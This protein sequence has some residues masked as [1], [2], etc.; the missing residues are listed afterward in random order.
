MACILWKS[1]DRSVNH[2]KLWDEI[3]WSPLKLRHHVIMLNL[4]FPNAGNSLFFLP[5]HQL[6]SR[7]SVS[8][9]VV[10]NC[11]PARH[12][13]FRQPAIAG[14]RIKKSKKGWRKGGEVGRGLS[15][16][17]KIIHIYGRI[18]YHLWFSKVPN[19]N[20]RP[21]QGRIPQIPVKTNY[22]SLFGRSD[23][24]IP[25]FP[26]NFYLNDILTQTRS[27]KNDCSRWKKN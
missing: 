22:C 19:F 15:K 14:W 23:P 6:F 13:R 3:H 26:S 4:E 21:K 11:S 17:Q 5:S 9:S 18:K 24:S 12:T 27:R 2:F 10:G 16:F 20:F 1:S 25:W 8:S 7:Q